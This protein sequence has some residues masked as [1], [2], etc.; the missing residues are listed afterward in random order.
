VIDAVLEVVAFDDTFIE[1]T[2]NDGNIIR[3]LRDR[4][5]GRTLP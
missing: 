5:G 3:A 4:F 1:I 2:T